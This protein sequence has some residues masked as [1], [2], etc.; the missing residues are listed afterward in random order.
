MISIAPFISSRNNYDLLP[1]FLDHIDLEGLSLINID[2]NSLL[3]EVK[4]GQKICGENNISFIENKGR[5]LQWA[6]KTIIDNVPDNIKFVIWCTHDAYPVSKN[7]F[8]KLNKLVSDGKLDDF[9]VVGFNYFGPMIGYENVEE[10]P[11]NTC[12]ILGKTPLMY[13]PG[14]GGYYRKGDMDLDW[15]KY[16]KPFAVESPSDYGW[17]INVKLFKKFILPSNNFQLFGACEDL[18]L[19]FLKEN[20]FNIVLPNFIAWHNQSIKEKF[21][22]PLNSANKWTK[23]GLGKKYFGHYRPYL[24]F[25]KKKWGW[26]RDNRETFESVKNNYI[27]TL[28]YDFYNHD[29]KKGPLK[30]FNI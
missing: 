27:N 29:Y 11:K 17:M 26:D 10:I 14:R 16:G 4:K 3:S 23:L 13:S 9:G 12:G 25:W 8:T 21:N 19:Q 15:S 7:F 2:D 30:Y 24:K 22:I 28:L 20:I 5:G 6:W 18:S 1:F